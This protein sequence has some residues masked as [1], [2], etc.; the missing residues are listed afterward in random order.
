MYC[1]FYSILHTDFVSWRGLHTTL[2]TSPYEQRDGW[3]ISVIKFCGTWYMCAFD[4]EDKIEQKQ[5]ETEKQKEMSYWGYKFE[6]Y[7]TSGIEL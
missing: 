5:N 2:L 1:T 7:M 6:Q 3:K 4:T